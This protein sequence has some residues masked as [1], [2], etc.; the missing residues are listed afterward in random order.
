MT[1]TINF[2]S[3]GSIVLYYNWGS[4][5]WS[6]ICTTSAKQT[7]SFA[8]DWRSSISRNWCQ[9]MPRKKAVSQPFNLEISETISAPLLHHVTAPGIGSQ[10]HYTPP[11]AETP[12][13]WSTSS[14]LV[15]PVSR[16][17]IKGRNWERKTP[18][19]KYSKMPFG[20]YKCSRF[21]GCDWH[22]PL[23]IERICLTSD[24]ASCCFR[25]GGEKN[26]EVA[27][28][29]VLIGERGS[30]EEQEKQAFP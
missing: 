25:L 11:T 20:W 18:G 17:R 6:L 8:K 5:S 14:A 27:P 13:S 19:R 1:M 29:H 2:P 22:Q 3:V 10:L 4:Q 15:V 16:F 24:Y 30:A 9:K 28:R 12:D 26:L 7:L 21:V 23:D